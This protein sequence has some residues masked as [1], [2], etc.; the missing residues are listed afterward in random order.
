MKAVAVRPATE[1]ENGSA[2][3][4]WHANA[5]PLRLNHGGET[6]DD[7]QQRQQDAATVRDVVEQWRATPLPEGR[8]A[9]VADCGAGAESESSCGYCE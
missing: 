7:R 2:A 8:T 1:F 5:L 6:T 4:R 3:V 9:A